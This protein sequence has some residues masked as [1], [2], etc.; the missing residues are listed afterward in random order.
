MDPLN[1]VPGLRIFLS[2]K[3]L[4]SLR[5]QMIPHP[6]SPDKIRF[7]EDGGYAVFGGCDTLTVGYRL[8]TL[9]LGGRL[10]TPRRLSE[11]LKSPA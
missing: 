3:A 9:G 2:V 11:P 7:R 8:G 10:W 6:V 5:W 4:P 1:R